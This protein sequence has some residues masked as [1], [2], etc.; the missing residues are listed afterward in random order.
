MCAFG[1]EARESYENLVLL[2]DRAERYLKRR[3]A[4]SLPRARR[5]IDAPAE[6]ARLRRLVS[7]QA[8]RPLIGMIATDSV[9]CAYSNRG[10]LASLAKTG[11]ATPQH[12]IFTKRVA[13]ISP[14]LPGYA[15]AYR[16]YLAR[17]RPADWSGVIPDCAPRV[18]VWPGRGLLAFGVDAAS[19]AMTLT[20]Y[21]HALEIQSRAAAHDQYT[22][23]PPA[24]VLAAELHYGGFE[25]GLVQGGGPLLGRIALLAGLS[26][27]AAARW[28]RFLGGLGACCVVVGGEA[29][30][31]AA[32]TLV[33]GRRSAPQRGLVRAT[34]RFGGIDIVVDG[35]RDHRWLDASSAV[36]RHSPHPPC[37][38]VAEASAQRSLRFSSLAVERKRLEECDASTRQQ[39]KAFLTKTG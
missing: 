16:R 37:A 31:A 9:A 20:V 10:D 35:S 8:G 34:A 13:A 17:H 15:A 32:N 33:L 39:I 6:I 23:L 27:L 22:S 11:P 30:L 14:Q 24:E 26:S 2:V 4:W 1:A 38:V 3:R 36:L 5:V 25:T 21:R 12:A 29:R 28:Q 7:T 18:V 19:A